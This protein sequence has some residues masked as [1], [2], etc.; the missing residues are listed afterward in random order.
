MNILLVVNASPWGGTLANTALRFLRAALADGQQ[1]SAVW[2]QGEGVYN[3]LP[4]RATDPGATDLLQ[5]WIEAAAAHGAELLLC[6]GAALRRLP[7]QPSPP[8]PFREAGLAEW[9]ER[10]GA[11]DRVVAF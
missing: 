8:A 6:S 4:G 7:A 2:F 11:C 10:A 3:A 5:A 1:V 9:L